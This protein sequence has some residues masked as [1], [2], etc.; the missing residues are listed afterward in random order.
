MVNCWENTETRKMVFL[1][2]S[3]QQFKAKIRLLYYDAY[4]KGRFKMYDNNSQ[5]NEEQI[6][7]YCCKAVIFYMK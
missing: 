2:V 7:F 6:A 5:T 1:V 4:Y 3:R